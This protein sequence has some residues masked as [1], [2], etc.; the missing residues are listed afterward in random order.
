MPRPKTRCIKCR[1]T[2]SIFNWI[3]ISKLLDGSLILGRGNI[4]GPYCEKCYYKM[5]HKYDGPDDD[6]K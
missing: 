1:K 4:Q 3:K 5:V 6:L 2:T